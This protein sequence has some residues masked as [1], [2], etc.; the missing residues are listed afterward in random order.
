MIIAEKDSKECENPTL[1]EKVARK[2]VG[3]VRN[4]LDCVTVPVT[5]LR[6]SSNSTSLKIRSSALRMNLVRLLVNVVSVF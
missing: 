2:S 3:F 5:F 6:K 1:N 4:L